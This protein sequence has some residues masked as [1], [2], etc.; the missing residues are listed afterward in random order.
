MLYTHIDT[1]D[2]SSCEVIKENKLFFNTS[3]QL[4]HKIWGERAIL[5]DRRIGDTFLLALNAGFFK[6]LTHIVEV[7]ISDN[8]TIVGYSML[9]YNCPLK[10]TGGVIRGDVLRHKNKHDFNIINNAPEQ[11]EKYQQ[12]YR[13]L[14]ES[15]KKTNF[16]FYDLVQSNIADPGDFYYL[17][18]LESV[19]HIRDLY[20]IPQY[21]RECLPEDYHE[22]LQN[23]HKKKIK[24]NNSG[25]DMQLIEEAWSMST[26]G[27]DK[28]PYY[29][30]VINGKYFDG[31]RA[32]KL[33][34]SKFYQEIDWPGLKVLDL[35]T[36]MGMVPVY[37]LKYHGLDS[38]TAIDFNNHHILATDT[39][40]RAF[41]IPEEK[42]RIINID[43]D[44][45]DYEDVL[46]YG[47]DVVFCLSFLRWIKNKERL[48]KYLSN[49]RDIIFEAHD[50]DGD[51][52]S[53][54]KE[55]GYTKQKLLGE[56]R[57]GKSFSEDKRR[58][59]YHFEK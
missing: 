29:S 40:R 57:I 41:R 33:R 20:K 54:F 47:Y 49:F 35:G 38:A 31:E 46:G 56:S 53:I 22:F 37:L 14:T 23:L 4:Y 43:L 30:I 2:F 15:A 3:K 19:A 16:F 52:I 58:S 42:M 25:I 50:L 13:I 17:I 8:G 9:P 59:M 7:L 44:N 11:N 32:W 28:K 10:D 24:L 12:F 45:S 6:D 34:Y 39:V 21:H 18:D 27:M 26:G 36:C 48:L 1:I 51:V 55:M 5:W